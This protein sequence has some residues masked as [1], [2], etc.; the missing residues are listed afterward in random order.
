MAARALGR[1]PQCVSKGS[2]CGGIG[3]RLRPSR[4][5]ND[6]IFWIS[7]WSSGDRST[8][9]TVLSPNGAPLRGNRHVDGSCVDQQGSGRRSFKV[10]IGDGEWWITNT[11]CDLSNAKR[12]CSTWMEHWL[13][14]L[15]AWKPSGA[16]G[17][18][19][20]ASSRVES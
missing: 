14:P 3:S 19:V 16:A 15:T 7:E 18:T 1:D 8:G 9:A 2:A 17:H 12:F 10:D 20:T 4:D 13:I 11:S 5:D 6:G